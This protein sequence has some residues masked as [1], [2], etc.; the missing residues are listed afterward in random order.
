MKI[1]IASYK[2]GVPAE[3]RYQCV[4]A[5]LDVAFDDMRF[6]TPIDLDGTVEREKETLRYHG[7]ATAQIIRVC[8]RT[9]VEVPENWSVNFDWFFETDNAEFVETD[10][11]LRE[12]IFL[13]HPMVFRAPEADKPVEYSDPEVKKKSPFEDLKKKI[14]PKK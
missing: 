7:V 14:K 13:D 5:D 9:L 2:E 6:M 3:L 1:R 11:E 8:G 12:L 4:A 10:G